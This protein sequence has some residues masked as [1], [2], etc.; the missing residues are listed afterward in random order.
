MRSFFRLTGNVFALILCLYCAPGTRAWSQTP[1][2]Q[3]DPQAN[4]AGGDAS[5]QAVTIPGPMR[6]FLRMAAISQKVSPEEV[7][8]LLARNVVVEG[9]QYWQDKAR[10]P[11][12][13][14]SLLSKYLEQARALQ[15]LAGVEG[16]LRINHCSEAQPLLTILGYRLRQPC[17]PNTSLET[18]EPEKAFLTIDSGFPLAELEETLRGTQPFVH[19]FPSSK[20]PVLFT[21][22]DWTANDRED[23]D[24]SDVLSALVRNPGLARLYWALSRLDGQTRMSLRQ[25]P[26]LPKLQ[27]L[28][29][30][31]DFYGSHIYIDNGRVAVPG[32][33]AAEAAWNKL[34]GAKPDSPAEF[35]TRLL[36]KD[37]GWAAAYY[38][39]LSRVNHSQQAYFTEPKRLQRF[40]EALRGQDLSPSPARPVFRPDPGL[41]LLVTRLPFD[42]NGQPHVP[43]NLEIWKE[44][45]RR[46]SDSRLVR[47]WA[48][49]AAKWND[50][51]EQLVEAMFS[52]S[53]LNTRDGPMQVFL[54]L[55]EM[56][57]SRPPEQR[58]SPQTV[59]LL[60]DKFS[61]FSNQY[62]IFSEFYALNNDSIQ[63]F[64]SVAE[65]LDRVPDKIL[66]ANALGTFQAN[67]GI[68]QI[69]ARQ[70]QI[71][72]AHWNDSWQ[73]MIN[74]FARIA[75]AAQLYD[76]ARAS[77]VEVVRSAAGTADFSQDDLIALLAGPAQTDLEAQQVRHE[78]AGKIS[79]ALDAQ[80]LVSLDTLMALGSGLNQL[81]DGKGMADS[82]IRLAGQLREFE[83]PKPLFTT[84]E[85]SEWA[86]GL[87]NNKHTTLQMQTDLGKIIKAP[88]SPKELSE[89]RGQIVPFLRDTLVGLNYAYYEPPGAQMLHTNPLFVRSHDFSGEMTAGGEQ[90]WQTPRLFGRGWTASGGAH[91]AGS[92]ADLPYVLA[93]V[94]QDFIVP[95]NVQ[96]LIWE[97]LVPGLLTSAVLPRWWR[98]SQHELHAVA[99][100]QRFG[101]ELVAAA[102]ENEKLR[103]DLMD[104]LSDR[105]LPQR[106]EEMKQALRAGR[107]TEAVSQLAPA[108]SFQ[109][110]AE[111]RQRFPNQAALSPAGKD[112]DDLVK[113]FPDE[114]GVKRLSEDFGAPHPAL[115][116]TYG[117]ELLNVKPFPTFLGYSSRLLAES[118][119][120]N[121]LYWARLADE[122]GYSPVELHLL[123][124]Q[125]TRRM[126]EKIFATHLEDW[127]AVLRALRETGEE[128][129]NGKIASVPKAAAA[130][131][132]PNG[133]S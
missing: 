41:L 22:A 12:E 21:P 40:Y 75:S 126:V 60:A 34:V 37:E 123:V 84:A 93:Q 88:S 69:L 55:S 124:P 101:D 107:G 81:A 10:K 80:R 114:V 3:P 99:L 31:L 5:S 39:A 70:E 61:R 108:E 25:S 86:S 116:L 106:S 125:L 83:M 133:Q 111:F 104:I 17:G 112:L 15:N 35:V 48:K 129:R 72:V 26:G 90:A 46:K 66:R 73:R 4:Q 56:D 127:P 96:S 115:A 13:Y 132:R 97:D 91:L 51:P 62:L 74:P 77:L 79:A 130:P 87:Y 68:W 27:P 11:T 49:R 119:D 85:R 98:V 65:A 20:V 14:L 78:L 59:R 76:A 105:M 120:S 53:R 28:A 45:L 1:P 42:P 52:L 122:M 50:N 71:P 82:L 94:E 29:A 32:G 131:V 6:N 7:L 47:D 109:L 64:L 100:Y 128:F 118:W 43:G 44:I 23:H 92:L 89:A 57:R 24:K 54:A 102:A 103:Q 63:R 33:E 18:A 9:Y 110:A 30:V 58:L 117:R 95:E 8:P 36:S 2:K 38:D 19:P 16:V 121:N 113:Q 67:I